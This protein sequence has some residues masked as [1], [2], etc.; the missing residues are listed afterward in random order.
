MYKGQTTEMELN[1]CAIDKQTD[2]FT[3]TVVKKNK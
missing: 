1:G 3:V 2:G